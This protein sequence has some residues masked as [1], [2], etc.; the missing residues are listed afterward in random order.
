MFPKTL[1]QEASA[2][3]PLSDLRKVDTSE[4][5]LLPDQ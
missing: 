3:S 4:I 5:R 2:G 1:S